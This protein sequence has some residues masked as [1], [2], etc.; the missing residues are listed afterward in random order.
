MD[1][2]EELETFVTIVEAGS[3]AEAG[4]RL[5]RSPPAM[6]R[7]LA[8]LEERIGARLIERTTRRIAPTDAGLRLVEQARRILVELDEAMEDARGDAKPRG[9]LSIAAPLVFGR[10][11]VAPLVNAFLDLHPFVDGDLSLND[12]NVDLV[13]DRIDLAVRIGELPDSSLRVRRV[14]ELARVICASPTYLKGRGRPESPGALAEHDLVFFGRRRLG[15]PTWRFAEG[16]ISIAP[17]LSVDFVDAAVDAALA[18]RGL[19]QALAYQVASEIASGALVR[20]LR[21]YEGPPEPVHLVTPGGRQA[22][23][24][25]RAFVE[26]AQPRLSRTLDEVAAALKAR[27]NEPAG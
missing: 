11:H 15:T 12:R 26:F 9:R 25:V 13:E 27:A 10:R 18:G 6:T 7:T 22:P 1:R 23:V 8:A 19:V 17:R 21:S 2:V 16:A 4:R 5:G 20:V 24:R 14:G 3:L